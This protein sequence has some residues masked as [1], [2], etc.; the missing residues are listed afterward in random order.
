MEFGFKKI[1]QKINPILTGVV[2]H[3]WYN[4]SKPNEQYYFIEWLELFFS[5]GDRIIFHRDEESGIIE[6]VNVSIKQK[7]EEIQ[8]E[9]N[10][11]ITIKS[12]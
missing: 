7:S 11:K 6:I 3:Y 1:T 5:D 9:F 4:N 12:M 8:N 2:H 10:G